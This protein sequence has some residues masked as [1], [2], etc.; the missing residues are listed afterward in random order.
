MPRA[1]TEYV[2]RYV[3]GGSASSLDRQTSVA[4]GNGWTGLESVIAETVASG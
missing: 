4:D 2:G 3:F 1:L